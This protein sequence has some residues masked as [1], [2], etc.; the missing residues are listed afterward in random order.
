[1]VETRQA[2][3][4]GLQLDGVKQYINSK[5]FENLCRHHRVIVFLSA[6]VNDIP[7]NISDRTERELTKYMKG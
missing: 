1:L 4:P 2:F 7:E 3:V 6:G 5:R